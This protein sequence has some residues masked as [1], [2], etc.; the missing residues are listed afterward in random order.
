MS[1]KEQRA[2][3]LDTSVSKAAAAVTRLDDEY[4]KLNEKER[5]MMHI[6]ERLRREEV[7][8]RNALQEASD[9]GAER[10]KRGRKERDDA[11]VARLESALFETDNSSSDDD[12]QNETKDVS[13]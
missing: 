12:E 2:A 11:A 7:A 1:E 3:A 5:N 4:A 13:S 8:L 9:S 6:L 10:L